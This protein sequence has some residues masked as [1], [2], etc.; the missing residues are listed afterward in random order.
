M[1]EQWALPFLASIHPLHV[2]EHH[3]VIDLLVEFIDKQIK[4]GELEESEQMC[5][6]DNV[7]EE[8]TEDWEGG[9]LGE[10]PGQS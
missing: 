4:D 2:S 6:T 10:E 9:R 3:W 8:R 5:T 7:E 1:N